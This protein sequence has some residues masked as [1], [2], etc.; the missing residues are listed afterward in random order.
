ME[1]IIDINNI[2]KRLD[3]F[4]TQNIQDTSRSYIKKLID[5]DKVLVNN[6]KVKAGYELKENDKIVI[7]DELEKKELNIVPKKMNID[8]IYEDND[9]IVINKSKGVVVHPGNNNYTDTLVNG[10]LYSHNDNLSTVNNDAIRPGIVHRIDKD[11]TGVIVVAKNDIAHRL[12]S[13]QFKEHS[14][15]RKY[16]AIVKGI[17][18]DDEITIDRPIGRNPKDRLKMAVTNINSKKAITHIKVLKRYYDSKLTL[19]E[20]ILETGRTHQIRV[21]MKYIGYPLLGDLTYGN[22]YKFIKVNTHMLHAKTLG[23]I[24]PTK[25]EYVEFNV[26]EPEEFKEIIRKIED[27]EYKEN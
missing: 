11:T 13:D 9:V 6:K 7:I 16:I 18:K 2:N 12:L 17:V 4:L 15:T 1:Y 22:E 26:E 3:M 14:I 27:R 20:A 8:V 10:L 19:V 5:N 23:F 24:H 21:H 25:K